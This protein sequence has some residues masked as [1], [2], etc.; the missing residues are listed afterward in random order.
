[1]PKAIL[2]VGEDWESGDVLPELEMPV[3]PRIGEGV[4]VSG[5]TGRVRD[6]VHELTPRESEPGLV[7]LR[8]LVTAS[9][10]RKVLLG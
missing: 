5:L 6:V 1:M 7:R 4:T 8:V 2:V 10:N 9:T 3:V